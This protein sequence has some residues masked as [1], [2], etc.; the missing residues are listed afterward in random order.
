MGMMIVNGNQMGQWKWYTPKRCPIGKKMRRKFDT[1]YT[2]STSYDVPTI[3]GG[4]PCIFP[5]QLL[6]KGRIHATSTK[7][8]DLEDYC[9]D[10]AIDMG[11]MFNLEGVNWEQRL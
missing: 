4:D 11:A 2:A 7:R 9:S 8:C 10:M 3:A 5:N 6:E 1:R